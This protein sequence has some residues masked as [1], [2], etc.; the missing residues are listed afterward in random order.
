MRA[1]TIT[2][3]TDLATEPPAVMD[4]EASGFGRHSYPIEVGFVLPDGSTYCTLIRPVPQWTHWDDAAEQVHRISLKTVLEHGRGVEEVTRQLNARLSGQTLYCDG[5]AHD[6]VWLN[7][8]YEA[9]GCSPSFR[10]DNLRALLSEQE[11]A[12]WSV[13]KRQVATEMRL[14]R[15]RASADAKLLQRT[16]MRLR[17]PLG[18]AGA[19]RAA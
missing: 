7:T 9:A 6:Y 5:W 18:S 10:L 2:D 15:H 8:L 12:F 13:V 17:A 16:L 14:P 1:V 11:A 19:G 4:I 3:Y